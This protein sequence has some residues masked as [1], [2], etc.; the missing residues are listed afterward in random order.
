MVYFNSIGPPGENGKHHECTLCTPVGGHHRRTR[1]PNLAE[2][3]PDCHGE[4]R[5]SVYAANTEA[6]DL[7]WLSNGIHSGDAPAGGAAG[8]KAP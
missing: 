7:P 3:G 5:S 2:R 6:G 1:D 4:S 8:Q